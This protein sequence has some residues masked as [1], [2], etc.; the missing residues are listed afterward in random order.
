MNPE[1]SKMKSRGILSA[2]SLLFQSSYSAILGFAAFFILTL[3]SSTA[4]LGIYATVLASMS[5]FNYITN[6]GLGAALLQKKETRDLD[7]N[8]AFY[9]QLALV[10][11]AVIGGAIFGER[12]VSS[13]RDVPPDT[14][15]LYWALLV[16][17]FLLSLKSIPSILLEKKVEIYKNVFVS[18]V[19]NTVFYLIIIVMVLA[20][21][22]I[23]ALIAAVIVRAVIGSVLIYVMSPWMPRLMFSWSSAKE[24]LAYGIPFQGNSFLALVKD[25]LIVLY[26]G[27][28][29]GPGTL[30]VLMFAKKYAEMAV[31][32]ITDN[33]NRVIFPILA[34]V[35]DDKDLLS[36]SLMRSILYN[37]LIVFPI[38]IGAMFVFESFLRLVDGYYEKW[39]TAIFSFYF[40]SLSTL[41]VSL[42]TPFI[43]LFNATRHLKKSI[44]FMILWTTLMWILIPAG[45]AVYGYNAV[46]VV[47][48]LISLTVFLVIWQAKTIL[49]FQLFRTLQGVLIACAAMTLY[50]AAVKYLSLSIF[51]SP[52]L[53]VLLSVTGAPAVYG[54]II[55]WY[56]GTRLFRDVLH[57]LR[58]PAS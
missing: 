13:Y 28:T 49:S 36:K 3:Q 47:F 17:L 22:T 30:G 20:G 32:L 11:V 34:R 2:A 50:L 18:S 26:L 6:L 5:F 58:P 56:Y 8:T 4:L 44:G 51:N 31:R 7:L 38:I 37:C 43:N 42:T 53:Q 46:G 10:T 33:L 1:L 14:I 45:T 25:D 16:S 39:N 35:Q 57:T 48:F 15:Y 41:F 27:Q 21:Q 54:G 9:I 52:L 12:I 19:E 24:L 55:L 29:L 40:F 23:T